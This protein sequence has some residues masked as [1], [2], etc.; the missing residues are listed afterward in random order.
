[1]VL[2]LVNSQPTPTIKHAAPNMPDIE[3]L[4][5]GDGGG[6]G[7]GGFGGGGGGGGRRCGFLSAQNWFGI[8]MQE[9]P[10]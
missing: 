9:K 2:L 10:T 1:M 4:C 7:G 8:Y 5:A 3:D 6:G